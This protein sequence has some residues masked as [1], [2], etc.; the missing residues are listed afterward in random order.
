MVMEAGVFNSGGQ[1]QDTT[2][3]A[4]AQAWLGPIVQKVCHVRR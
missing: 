2:V 4:E 3:I 1:A